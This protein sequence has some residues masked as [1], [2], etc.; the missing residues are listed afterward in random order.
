MD[1]PQHPADRLHAAIAR[2]GA[3]V[4]VGLDPVLESLPQE[5]RARH[6]EPL[7][8]IAE[9]GRGVLHAIA[10]EQ[11]P[12]VP[13]VKFQSACY[14]RYGSRGLA[15]L[16]E[17]AAEAVRLGLVVIWDAK[18]GDIS[19]SAAHY[20]AAAKRL[21][22]HFITASAY[23]GP[24]GLQPFLD[25]GLGVF[26]LVRTSNPDSDA[27][28]NHK[29]ADGRTIAEMVAD[30]VAS[31][32]APRAG[33]HGLSDLGAVVGATKSSQAAALRARMPRQIFLVPGYGAQ[34]GTAEDIRAMLRP[35]AASPA[36]AGVLVTASRSVIYAKPADNQPWAEAVRAAAQQLAA[37]VSALTRRA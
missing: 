15:T 33:H 30:E 34:G 31:L 35:G 13:A 27:I 2:A 22:C 3:P 36:D 18:R 28:Q 12:I 37:E 5:L 26:A 20:A 4:C 6:Y 14:E 17:H 9:F 23:L 29:L 11:R 10:P 16:E 24:S 1:S 21:G 25:A 7:A 8:A 32:G 19:T